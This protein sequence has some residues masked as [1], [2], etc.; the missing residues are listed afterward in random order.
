M[1]GDEQE[2]GS[3]TESRSEEP[4]ARRQKPQAAGRGPSGKKAPTKIL[5]YENVTLGDLAG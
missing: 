3:L 1:R 4:G 5:S 2:T